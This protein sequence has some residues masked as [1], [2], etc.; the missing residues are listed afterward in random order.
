MSNENNK[1]C[2]VDKVPAGGVSGSSI[3]VLEMHPEVRKAVTRKCSDGRVLSLDAVSGEIVEKM[4]THEV[5]FVCEELKKEKAEGA[6]VSF[7]HWEKNGLEVNLTHFGGSLA[8]KMFVLSTAK[9]A[10]KTIIPHDWREELENDVAFPNVCT[11]TLAMKDGCS[12]DE[13]ENEHMRVIV[14]EEIIHFLAKW[15]SVENAVAEEEKAG[16]GIVP[17]DNKADIVCD[18]CDETLV[19]G[20]PSVRT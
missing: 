6:K 10:D 15:E 12:A 19:R 9:L 18:F 14:E 20:P 1:R 8:G 7:K 13:K 4:M 11:R 5:P 17:D 2:L 16:A 3:V